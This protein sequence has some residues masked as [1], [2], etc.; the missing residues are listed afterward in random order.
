MTVSALELIAAQQAIVRDLLAGREVDAD[1]LAQLEARPH[2]ALT[3][4]EADEA[5]TLLQTAAILTGEVTRRRSELQASIPAPSP[6]VSAPD[7]TPRFL[8]VAG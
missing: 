2:A 3:A 6:P 4:A 7:R 8:D 5:R 1:R